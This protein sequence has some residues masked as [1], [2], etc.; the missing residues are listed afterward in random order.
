[1]FPRWFAQEYLEA[2]KGTPPAGGAGGAGEADDKGKGDD[3]G[4]ADDTSSKS[5]QAGGG[6]TGGDDE[7]RFTQSDV[8]RLIAQRLNEEKEREKRRTAEARRAAEAAA[9]SRSG[10]WEAV[11]KERERDLA[12]KEAELEELRKDLAQKSLDSIRVRVAM[13]HKLPEALVLRLVGTDEAS[14]ERDARE[15]A[16]LIAP[17]KAP[18]TE[19][20]VNGKGTSE[21]RAAKHTEDILR[22]TGRYAP[23]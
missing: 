9:A 13:R 8:D 6:K 16:K 11:A 22:K 21:E 7:A 4:K 20:G 2:D 12:E 15:L 14:I 10:E 5:T 17:P 3:K 18:D 1:M 19:A 23:L